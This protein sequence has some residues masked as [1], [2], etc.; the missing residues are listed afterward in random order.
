MPDLAKC[1]HPSCECQVPKGGPFGKYCSEECREKGQ[2][3]ELR[4][5]CGHPECK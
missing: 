3:T 4:C 2:M 5:H 1:A